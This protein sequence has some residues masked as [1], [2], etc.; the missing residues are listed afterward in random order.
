MK[1]KLLNIMIIIFVIAICFISY[2][3]FFRKIEVTG[4]ILDKKNIQLIVG[5]TKKLEATVYPSD[6]S[7]KSVTWQSSDE[8]IITVDKNGLVKGIKQGEATITAISD[9][10]DVTDTCNVKVSNKKVEKIVLSKDTINLKIGESAQIE[11]RIVPDDATLKGIKYRSS[12]EGIVTVDDYGKIEAKDNGIAEIIITNEEESVTVKCKI[13]VGILV[14]KIVLDKK[15]LLLGLNEE[16]VLNATISPDNATNKEITWESTDPNVLNVDTEGKITANNVGEVEVIAKDFTGTVKDS[17]KVVVKRIE[18]EVTFDGSKKVY[19]RSELLGNLP[20]PTKKG[21]KFIGWYTSATGGEKV[22][23]STKVTSNLT[24][25]AH[26]EPYYEHVFIIGVDGLG[27]ALTKVSSPNFD[28]IFGNYAF[29]HDAK[30]E[31]ETISAQ[32]WGSILTGVAYNTHKYTNES[33]DN[34][35]KTSKSS[36]LSIFYYIRKAMPN[37]KLASIVN[38]NPINVGII[39]NDINVNMI[40]GSSDTVVTNEVVK[41]LKNNGAPT[42]MFVHFDEVDH[43]GHTYGGFSS[44]YY[45][46]VIDADKRIGQIFDTIKLIGALDKSLFIVVADHGET[47][48]GH[49]GHTK[50]ESS[51]VVAVYGNT[52]NKVTL[53]ENTQNRDVSAIVLYALG[54]DKPSHFISK[55]PSNLFNK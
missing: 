39:E 49:G 12:D 34:N 25:Y 4:V 30:T 44:S 23:V 29:R 41:Y 7:N 31:Y 47:S 9:N 38:W 54:I 18:F 22:S 32:N 15:D 55:V 43:A 36:N 42:L 50:E 52:V 51:A 6:A 46:A 28:R 48:G 45:N 10:K 21:M 37:A 5:E 13:I 16:E 20:T 33:I 8:E 1:D 24:L 3:L 14:D 27:A 19:Q 40:H 26:W 17:C 53:A 35:A 11:A 2:M